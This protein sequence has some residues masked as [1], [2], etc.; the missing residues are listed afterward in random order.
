MPTYFP[1]ISRHTTAGFVGLSA[2][3]VQLCSA[4]AWAQSSCSSDG[5][6]PP[7]ALVERF[8]SA[9]CDTCWA[10]PATPK[11]RAAELALDWIVPSAKGDEAPLSA[12]ASQD[13]MARLQALRMD[14][15][16]SA[17]SIRHN[18]ATPSPA[19]VLTL[20]VAHGVALGGYMGTSIELKPARGA[21]L[22]R[23]PLT[24]WLLMVEAVP[25][26][27]DGTPVARS[28][29]RNALWPVLGLRNE[30]L[31][32]EQTKNRQP[33]GP[34]RLFES[35]PMS[36]PAGANPERLRVVGWV[37]DASGRVIASAASVCAK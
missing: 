7:A 9:D 36:I 15:P 3:A 13:A 23:Q 33:P 10:D 1:F 34:A 32:I 21:A 29:V 27:T 18:I 19:N 6:R 25:A 22:P 37:E 30:L 20:R 12:A 28:L 26:G 2:L 11:A 35:R 16:R 17:S 4:S 5:Q 14:T 8:I 31:N 24:A